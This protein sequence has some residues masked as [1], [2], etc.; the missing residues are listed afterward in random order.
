MRVAAPPTAEPVPWGVAS[1]HPPRLT[2]VFLNRFQG[3]FE[4][5]PPFEQAVMLDEGHPVITPR[6]YFA[7]GVPMLWMA[8]E[9][10]S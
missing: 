1:R 6:H 4:C 10:Q 7:L 3:S 9:C 2:L 8:V 5:N